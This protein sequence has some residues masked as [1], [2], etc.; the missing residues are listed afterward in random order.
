[1]SPLGVYLIVLLFVCRS[2]FLHNLQCP[3]CRIVEILLFN[4][5]LFRMAVRHPHSQYN[6]RNAIRIKMTGIR[7]AAGLLQFYGEAKLFS[8]STG[9]MDGK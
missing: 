5:F 8:R 4:E 6:R 1:M 9:H 2:G 7:T 3:F